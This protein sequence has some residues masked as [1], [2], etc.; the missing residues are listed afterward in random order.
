MAVR[1]QHDVFSSLPKSFEVDLAQAS[2]LMLNPRG[3]VWHPGRGPRKNS[4]SL[5]LLLGWG[6]AT[7]WLGAGQGL[8]QALARANCRSRF[9]GASEAKCARMRAG[10]ALG[11]VR[12]I[13]Y[14]M[15]YQ[16]M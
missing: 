16:T 8:V 6:W 12:F 2:Q 10:C 1:L 7:A 3:P 9:V 13:G 4:E 14:L 11:F 15:G 5:R